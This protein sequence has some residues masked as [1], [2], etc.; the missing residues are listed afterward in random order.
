MRKLQNF[1]KIQEN[2]WIWWRLPSRSSKMHIL[3]L[4]LENCEISAAEHFTEKPNLLN[5]ANLSTIPCP[6]LSEE[7]FHLL[8]RD[9]LN[10]YFV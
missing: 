2:A 6:G 4:A 5:L 7:Y 1:N 10:L 8:G 3:T 9:P